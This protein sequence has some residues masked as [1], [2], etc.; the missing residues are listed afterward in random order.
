MSVQRTVITA[1]LDDAVAENY[2]AV[3]AAMGKSVKMCF[4][5]ILRYWWGRH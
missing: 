3:E 2:T 4:S 5:L 1:Y